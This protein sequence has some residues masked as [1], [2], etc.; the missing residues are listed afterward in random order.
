MLSYTNGYAMRA[1]LCLTLLLLGVFLMPGA[2]AVTDDDP[3]AW[4]EDVH[5]AKPL[6]WVK[7]RNAKSQAGLKADPETCGIPVVFMSTQ[8]ALR[9]RL[10]GLSLGSDDY[11][12]KP[13]ALRELLLR[14]GRADE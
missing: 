5:G 13:V 2:Q 6:A 3:Y 1:K 4:L 14:P 12:C 9:D 8:A 10:A 11:L 7:E